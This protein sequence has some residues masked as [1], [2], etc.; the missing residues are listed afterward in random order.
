MY[1]GSLL[2]LLLSVTACASSI[3]KGI[4]HGESLEIKECFSPVCAMR[5]NQE[6]AVYKPVLKSRHGVKIDECY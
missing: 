6:H 1:Y 3:A 4:K 2:V 5:F